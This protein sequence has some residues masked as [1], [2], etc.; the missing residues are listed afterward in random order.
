MEV[1][2]NKALEKDREM[3]C[4]SA[5]EL[6]ADLRRLKRDSESLPAREQWNCRGRRD[7]RREEALVTAREQAHKSAPPRCRFCWPSVFCLRWHLD[8]W[9]ASVSGDHLRTS[10][11]L[12]HE[13]TFRRGEIRSARF[14]PDGQTILYS[15][16]WQGNPVEI[17]SARQGTV[18][19]RS[20]GL[21]RAELAGGFVDG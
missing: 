17:F 19:S 3:R 13:I 9:R 5:A 6:R 1:I 7:E 20:L 15:A 10:A 16:A 11:P 2:L 21:G 4:Q 12:Y 8:C 14:A 18:E